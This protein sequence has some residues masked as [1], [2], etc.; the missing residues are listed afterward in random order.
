[1]Y[2]SPEGTTETQIRNR[3]FCRPS[4]T[5]FPSCVSPALKRRAILMLSL[6]DESVEFPKGIAPHISLPAWNRDTLQPPT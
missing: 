4:G 1:M 5:R 3:I 2:P 6:R